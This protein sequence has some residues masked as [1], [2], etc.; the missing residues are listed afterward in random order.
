MKGLFSALKTSTLFLLG[1][2]VHCPF[3][4]PEKFLGVSEI[5]P[6]QPG[7][8]SARPQG[9]LV[10]SGRARPEAQADLRAGR[11]GAGRTTTWAEPS[12]FRWSETGFVVMVPLG[13]LS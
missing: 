4:T 7:S 13:G 6:F 5:Y 12:Y 1:S 9:G 11:S 8:R 2:G 3:Q 10:E